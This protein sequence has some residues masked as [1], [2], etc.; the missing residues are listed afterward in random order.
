[1]LQRRETNFQRVLG[2]LFEDMSFD[3]PLSEELS[4]EKLGAASA[5]NPTI[6]ET[7][8]LRNVLQRLTC[9]GRA[10]R[11]AYEASVANGEVEP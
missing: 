2:V 6:V 3:T 7:T 8:R 10:D 11:L 9:V 5:E 1:M 4:A